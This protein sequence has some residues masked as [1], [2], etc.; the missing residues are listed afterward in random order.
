M[1]YIEKATG[2]R[3]SAKSTSML[4]PQ[5]APGHHAV[6]TD[7]QDGTYRHVV[8]GRVTPTGRVIIF[9]PQSGKRMSYDQMRRTY[10][11]RA[12][13]YLLEAP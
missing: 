9:D 2:L 12:A 5:A 8:Y 4:D 13:P 10:G 1:A 6:F 11:V 7:W 3:A